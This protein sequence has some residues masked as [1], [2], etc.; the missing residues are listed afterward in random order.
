[1]EIRT[2]SSVGRFA[3]LFSCLGLSVG[4]V[5]QSQSASAFPVKPIEI[6][7]PW[8]PGG[9]V[10]ILGR[11]VAQSLGT[12]LNQ[13]AIVENRPGASGVVGSRHVASRPA[14]GHSLLMMND[15]FAI[16]AA[17][18][19][20]LQFDPKKDIAGVIVIA[21]APQLLVTAPQ[22]PFRS[23]SDVIKAAQAKD[24]KL[25][26][27][28]CGAGTPGH[29]AAESLNLSLKMNIL[30]I[31]YKG[32]APT[33]VD[34]IGGQLDL[35]WVTLSAAVAHIKAGKLKPIAVSSAER[36]PVL[37]DVPTLSESGAPGVSFSS[38][39]GVGVPG[40]TPGPVKNQLYDLI[41]SV[42]K[43]DA[44][45]KRLFDLGFTPASLKESP[46]VFQQII[47]R[48]IDR[49]AQVAKQINFSLD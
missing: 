13:R 39:Q 3:V 18:S 40:G 19:R 1:M 7:V 28:A 41:V 31:S 4:A 8:A 33:L 17:T 9:G 22:S 30:H 21:Y 32:C 43:T 15:T 6:T 10:D 35:A 27:G 23:F 5:A 49:F 48:D 25:S 20:K 14:D 47:E 29:L 11:L 12:T 44:F 38:W 45:Q 37:P 42:A 36:S 26:Y 16:T 2:K 24:A 34:V 46:A